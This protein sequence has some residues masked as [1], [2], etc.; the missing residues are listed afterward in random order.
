MIYPPNYEVSIFVGHID[1]CGY[2]CNSF[3]KVDIMHHLVQF[4]QK[5]GHRFQLPLPNLLLFYQ[6]S[7]EEMPIEDT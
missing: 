7:N 4:A 1:N 6:G 3:F 2:I 5:I